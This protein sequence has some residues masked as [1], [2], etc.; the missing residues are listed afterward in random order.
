[1]SVLT[2]GTGAGSGAIGVS[3]SGERGETSGPGRVERRDL[4]TKA[5]N[6]LTGL[7]ASATLL[8]GGDDTGATGGEVVLTA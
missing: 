2:C 7:G 3:V 4:S 8:C 5:A 1:M 6:L